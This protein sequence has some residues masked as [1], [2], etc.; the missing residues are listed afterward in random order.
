MS[1]RDRADCRECAE[2][3]CGA[4]NGTALIDDGMDV[5]EVDCICASQNHE[6]GR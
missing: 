2:G 6:G 1:E 3:K 4:C 5:V